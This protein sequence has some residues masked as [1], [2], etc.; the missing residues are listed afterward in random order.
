MRDLG[1]DEVIDYTATDPYRQPTDGY[2]AILNAVRD[3]PLPR[4]RGL[5]RRGGTLVTLTGGPPQAGM[6]KLHNL[7]SPTRTV[8]MYVASDGAIL[9][10]LA[11]MIERGQVRPIVEDVYPWDQLADAHRRVATGRVTGKV[12]V[13]PPPAG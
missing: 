13:I 8:V 12:A 6:A 11:T 3:A 10:G 1:A 9:E 5:L 7:V 2:E 4:L